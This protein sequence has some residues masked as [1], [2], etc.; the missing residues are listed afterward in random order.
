MAR[1][2]LAED[3]DVLRML[4]LDTLEDEGYTIDEATDGDEAYQKIM[5]Q[6]YDLVLLDYM[7]PGMTGIEVIEK[8]RRH[9]DK[10]NLK[11]MMLTAKSQ[12][13]DRERA[14]EIG[15]NYFF[16]KPFSPLELM[17][18]VGGILSEHPVD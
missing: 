10:Q 18:V 4:V 2:L 1:I 16:S 12:Q 7:M 3:E 15:A 8:V 17:D 13:S 6:H 9:P 11:I 14:E 5:S